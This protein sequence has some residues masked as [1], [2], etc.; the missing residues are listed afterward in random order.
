METN[1]DSDFKLI[2]KLIL[3]NKKGNQANFQEVEVSLS[4]APHPH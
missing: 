4:K 1:P 2:T 3:I